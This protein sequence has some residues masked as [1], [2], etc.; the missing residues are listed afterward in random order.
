MGLLDSLLGGGGRQTLEDFTSRHEKGMPIDDREAAQHYERIAGQL[1]QDDYREA[2]RDSLARLSPEERQQLL[3]ELQQGARQTDI[4]FPGLHETSADPNEL[5]GVMSRMH[6]EQ[7]GLLQ[8]LLGGVGGRAGEGGGGG[9]LLGS[10]IGKAAL[11]G[12]AAMAAR[13]F[14]GKP[15]L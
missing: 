10:K 14:L 6:G 2:A 1:G 11:L 8:Q 15:R 4:N 9:G 7:P 3:A 12:V 13:R 5:A